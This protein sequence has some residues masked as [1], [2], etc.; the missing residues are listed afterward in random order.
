M[1]GPDFITKTLTPILA[2]V[3]AVFGLLGTG[4]G[5]LNY[6]LARRKQ[7]LC[8]QLAGRAWM[9]KHDSYGI[10]HEV[11]HN[12]QGIA[13]EVII[14]NLSF[15]DVTITECGLRV[16]RLWRRRYLPFGKN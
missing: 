5:I 16:G 6:V 1:F 11:T 15:F 13:L 9:Y 3:G 8:I 12:G 4:L 10:E 14:K 7:R 2:I